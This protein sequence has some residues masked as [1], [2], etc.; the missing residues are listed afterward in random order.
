M[1]TLIVVESMF[2]NTRKVADAVMLGVSTGLP[3]ESD[4]TV[5]D[6]GQAPQRLAPEIGFLVVGAPT[7][8]FGMSR[9]STRK[10]AVDQGAK[11][12]VPGGRASG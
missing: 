12:T 6:V 8:A 1:D 9:P 2:G 5:L 7:H 11:A 4:I 10:S 3:A